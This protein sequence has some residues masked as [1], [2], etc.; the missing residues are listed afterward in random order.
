MGCQL[1]T[2]AFD[3]TMNEENN[4]DPRGKQFLAFVYIMNTEVSGMMKQYTESV[5]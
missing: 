3:E 2:L 4:H 1:F 5:L